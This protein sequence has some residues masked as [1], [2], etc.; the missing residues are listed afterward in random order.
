MIAHLIG[1]RYINH[2][3]IYKLWKWEEFSF[4][5]QLFHEYFSVEQWGYLHK[6]DYPILGHRMN[7]MHLCSLTV[8]SI[9]IIFWRSLC[10][11]EL[12]KKAVWKI[13]SSSATILNF[14]QF[15]WE[16]FFREDQLK[17]ISHAEPKSQ[18]RGALYSEFK[19][20]ILGGWK[21]IIPNIKPDVLL[22]F[23]ITIL[24]AIST[25]TLSTECKLAWIFF[26]TVSWLEANFDWILIQEEIPRRAEGN[27][28]PWIF[29]FE[30]QDDIGD[31]L[32]E[33]MRIKHS[34]HMF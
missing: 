17:K 23:P 14:R 9:E 19:F 33:A 26:D 13:S 29:K 25:G 20:I 27:L 18:T 12:T 22:Y 7:I 4:F 31:F 8:F 3:K 11:S 30:T 15:F 34:N 16:L 1:R 21:F 5:V 10:I 32:S 6:K 24:R 28:C 2:R